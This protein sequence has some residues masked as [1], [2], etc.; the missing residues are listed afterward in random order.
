MCDSA[1]TL[2]A[3]ENDD[4]SP[5]GNPE[6]AAQHGGALWRMS[7]AAIECNHDLAVIEWNRGAERIFGYSRGEAIGR[8]LAGLLFHGEDEGAWRRLVEE[9][10]GARIFEGTRKDGSAALCEWRIAALRDAQDRPSGA[11]CLGEDVT[12]RVQAMAQ[13]EQ[14]DRM[15][16]AV[17]DTLPI[18]VCGYDREGTFTFHDGKGLAAGGLQPGQFLGMNVLTIYESA[19]E[20]V[21]RV[22][23]GALAGVPQY[24]RSE[25][26][27]NAWESWYVPLGERS[28][29]GTRMVSITLDAS[30]AKRRE[31]QELQAKLDVIEQQ[32][33]VIR[34]LA[35]PIIEVW[36]GV[37]TLPMMGVI[38]STRAADVMENLLAAVVSKRA[39]FA[40]LDLT[41]VEIVDTKTASYLI[42]LVR[43]IRLLGAEGIITGIRP[44]VAQTMV[45]LGLD[46]TGIATQA[47]LRAG[48]RL[49][50]LRIREERDVTA[51]SRRP[52]PPE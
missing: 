30:E 16:R 22:L 49:C 8:R 46:L 5:G 37:L 13:L 23:R 28:H 51:D 44:T 41:G 1:D 19:G 35:T 39:R 6:R 9:E 14:R 29:G 11:L 52:S 42:E 38:D 50:M 15:F 47:N 27:N 26:H 20:E 18:V 21:V 48:L 40:I 31:Q 24:S 2:T 17:L 4:D 10:G 3:M 33:K 32:Q 36:D 25:V 12:A 34:D 45:S 43:A 7:C